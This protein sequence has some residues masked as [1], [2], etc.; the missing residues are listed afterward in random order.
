MVAQWT[1]C[2]E[3][4]TSHDQPE[5]PVCPV[6]QEWSRA[7]DRVRDTEP[8]RVISGHPEDMEIS[9]NN[10]RSE[11]W[12]LVSFDTAPSPMQDTDGR[13]IA[14]A[15]ALFER[16]QYS[17]LD[18]K[19]ARTAEKAKRADLQALRGV[20]EAQWQALSKKP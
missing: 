12:K 15:T 4:E 6:E 2:S 9:L 19:A 7:Y 8:Y 1:W 5:C 13:P 20:W 18:H 16:E 11:G 17:V 3:C 14:W 10:M